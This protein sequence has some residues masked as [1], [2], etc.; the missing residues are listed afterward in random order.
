MDGSRKIQGFTFSREKQATTGKEWSDFAIIQLTR[1][2][3]R[4]RVG[5]YAQA[6]EKIPAEFRGKLLQF[7]TAA[8]KIAAHHLN[9]RNGVLIG[10]VV[11]LGKTLM[12]PP[13]PRSSR[14]IMTWKP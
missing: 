6:K 10:D 13:W 4:F 2:H 5:E 14:K 1:S 8:V 3:A 11:G 12:A 7:Q 9:K